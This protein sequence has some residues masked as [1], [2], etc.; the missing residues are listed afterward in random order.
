M[1]PESLDEKDSWKCP[2]CKTLQAAKKE[3]AISS[4]PGVL[5]LHIKRFTYGDFG[6][7]INKSVSYPLN[8]LDLSP[9]V[10]KETRSKFEHPL[11]YDLCGVITHTGSMRMG[12]YTCI[13]RML[14]SEDQEEVGWRFFDDD[15]VRKIKVEKVVCPDAYVLVYRLKGTEAFLKR[16]VADNSGKRK[17]IDTMNSEKLLKSN[18]SENIKR[19]SSVEEVGDGSEKVLAE[20]VRDDGGASTT[21]DQDNVPPSNN[22]NTQNQDTAD[23]R[24]VGP[25]ESNL[26]E[27]NETHSESS[28]DNIEA[29]FPKGSGSS[30]HSQHILWKDAADVTEDDLD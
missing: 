25:S 26:G 13:T 4:P 14:G 2:K 30:E 16:G 10:A 29:N 23:D 15:S 1:E 17:C 22:I 12:H 24:S 5:L 28:T 20:A 8:D 7:K 6:Q 3:M 21:T 18:S 9:F 11:V 19:N 27:S